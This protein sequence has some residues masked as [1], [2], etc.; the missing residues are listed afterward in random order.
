MR[1]GQP[2]PSPCY[3]LAFL[4]ALWFLQLE[5]RSHT[6]DIARGL[7]PEAVQAAAALGFRYVLIY[8]QPY[9]ELWESGVL[10]DPGEVVARLTHSLGAPVLQ[11][12]DLIAFDI[13]PNRA[14]IPVRGSRHPGPE[15]ARPDETN[16]R[17][18]D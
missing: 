2:P 12:R 11:T 3:D 17:P 15:S 13:A 4:R 9:R 18:R 10:R 5:T 6:P 8:T 16:S 7:E 1:L 14:S